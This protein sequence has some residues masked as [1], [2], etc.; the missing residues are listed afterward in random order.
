MSEMKK[1]FVG[2]DSGLSCSCMRDPQP[3][4]IQDFNYETLQYQEEGLNQ[5]T[6]DNYTTTEKKNGKRKRS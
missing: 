5:V 2:S 1:C 6:L 3:S 4:T